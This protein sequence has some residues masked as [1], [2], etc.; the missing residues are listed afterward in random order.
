GPSAILPLL[1]QRVPSG[2]TLREP[3]TVPLLAL[4]ESATASVSL[5]RFARKV[6]TD[7]DPLGDFA[8]VLADVTAEEFAE[9]VINLSVSR[10]SAPSRSDAKGGPGLSFGDLLSVAVTA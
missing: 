4:M 10:G 1:C 7:P 3:P 6:P 5:P 2:L 8:R 9:V